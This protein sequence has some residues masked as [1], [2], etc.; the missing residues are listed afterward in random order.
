M[1][2]PKITD[3]KIVGFYSG[4]VIFGAGLLML[5]PM[6]I[7]GLFKEWD[8]LLNFTIGILITVSIGLLMQAFCRIE[9][10]LKWLHGLV[11]TAFSW[12]LALLILPIPFYLSGQFSSYIDAMFDVMSGLTTTGLYLLQDLDHAA[13]GINTW[14]HL[15]SYAGG[16]GI[17]VIALTFLV[18]GTSGA[19][20]MYVAEGKEEQLMPNVIKTA[21]A[22]WLISL[23]YLTIGSLFLFF[24]FWFIGMQPVRAF[25]HAL[26][27]FMGAWSTGGF[28]PQSNNFVYYNSLLVEFIAG[29]IMVIGS[30][31]F[32]LHWAVWSQ[33]RKEIYRNLESKTFTITILITLTL[34]AFGL[35]TL[36]V[37]KDLSALFSKAMFQIASGHTTT[38]FQSIFARQFVRQ[39]GPWTT[40]IVAVA[41]ALGGSAASTA[42]GFKA[43]RVGLV[44]KTIVGELRRLAAPES[45]VIVE[46]FHHLKDRVLS[47]KHIRNTLIIV[48]FYIIIYFTGSLIGLAYGYPFSEALFE[49]VSAGSNSGL[50]VGITNPFMP[51]GL[52]LTFIMFMWLGRLE[53]L[54]F[55]AL[56]GFALGALKRK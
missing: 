33:D 39:W 16:Q 25:L 45:A 37:Y 7:S 13:N 2:K 29:I 40:L 23:I 5:V 19:F 22:I 14:R 51:L 56:A 42:G 48:F 27:V 4:K 46:R 53:F 50:S 44:F 38:G 15:L 55:F 32:A 3:L 17:I 31:N 10:E 12:L 11:I 34:T 54:A 9:A 30:L 1:I 52:K 36:G 8:I 21:R 43:L 35:S 24:A 18:K 47:E 26:W 28:A 6:L 49:S 20:M 41:M